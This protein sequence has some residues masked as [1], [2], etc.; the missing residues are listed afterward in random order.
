MFFM[1]M[2]LLACYCVLVRCTCD[3]GWPLPG[4]RY[5]RSEEGSAK[6]L[7]LGSPVEENRQALM[8]M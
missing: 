4:Q 8:L 2:Q 5:N 7:K 1:Y 6:D 3:E